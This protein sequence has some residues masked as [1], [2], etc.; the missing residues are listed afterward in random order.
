[1][2]SPIEVAVAA[3]NTAR[4]SHPAPRAEQRRRLRKVQDYP[5]DLTPGQ[6]SGDAPG[7]AHAQGVLQKAQ[8]AWDAIRDAARDSDVPLGALAKQSSA[9]ADR[10][11]RS[12]ASAVTTLERQI[13]HFDGELDNALSMRVEPALATEIRAHF[14]DRP[15]TDVAQHLDDP[16]IASAILTAPA[17]LSGRTS[18]EFSRLRDQAEQSLAPDA[19]RKR[20]ES[21][22]ALDTVTAAVGRF[23]SVIDS[24]INEW[25]RAA[26]QPG[27]MM[28]LG[29]LADA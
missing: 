7:V 17:V 26:A 25:H 16:R 5:L 12:L 15:F 23:Q 21:R 9:V 14:R 2:T 28:R 8:E 1:M 13:A 11:T 6:V 3:R 18:E 19:H 24:R 29:E 4:V 27:A 20:A 10:A 22:R